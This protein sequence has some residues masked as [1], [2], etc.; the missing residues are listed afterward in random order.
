MEGDESIHEYF[1]IQA[2]D[3]TIAKADVV[4]AVRALGYHVTPRNL[5]YY[6]G[7]GL[8]P[9]ALR[10]GSRVGVYPIVIVRLVVW[11]IRGRQ[12]NLTIEA[13]RELL[14]LWRFIVQAER[15][16][17]VDLGDF[18][19]LAR[20][21]VLSVEASLAVSWVFSELAVLPAADLRAMKFILKDQAIVQWTP[22]RPVGVRFLVGEITAS[23]SV[24]PIEWAEVKLPGLEQLSDVDP[25][26]I[27]LGV[28]DGAVFADLVPKHTRASKRPKVL[29]GQVALPL[30]LQE[31]RL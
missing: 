14:P 29:T 28:A 13:L 11:L 19:R 31:P 21:R 8:V 23:G 30:N 3:E 25:S 5:D 27:V 10:S 7:A 15:G 1:A 9:Q 20:K 18:E 17:V 24:S 4:P 12:R 26:T 2:S 6:V 22:E 16:G